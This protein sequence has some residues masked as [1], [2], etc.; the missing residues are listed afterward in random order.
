M[1]SLCRVVRLEVLGCFAWR[2]GWCR[3]SAALRV[4]LTVRA[5]LT[6]MTSSWP[7]AIWVQAPHMGSA[8]AWFRMRPVGCHGSSMVACTSMMCDDHPVRARCPPRPL[9]LK[10]EAR[11]V[12]EEVEAAAED[13]AGHSWRDATETVA[14]AVRCTWFMATA[15]PERPDMAGRIRYPKVAELLLDTSYPRR[16]LRP[17]QLPKS[18][19]KVVDQ[20]PQ[21]PHKCLN[22]AQL[23][24]FGPHF[25]RFGPASVK[26]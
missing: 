8:C 3:I 1:L 23:G 24:R 19:P 18:C 2:I 16:S 14:R 10:P 17:P 7:R 5:A 6:C 20:V 15:S 4:G 21:E 22:S 9:Q 12:L 26:L 25:V 13:S 11:Y